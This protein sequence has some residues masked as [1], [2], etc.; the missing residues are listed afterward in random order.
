MSET[1]DLTVIEIKPEQAPAL[2]IANGLDKYL[3]QIREYAK[4]APDVTTQKGRDRIGSLARSVGVSK[5][6]IEEPG[7]AYLKHLKEA[8]KP[9]EEELRR[10][11]R[12][13]DAIRDAILLPRTEYEQ[14]QERLRVE[15]Q[16]IAARVAYDK[17]RDEANDLNEVFD[18]DKA[19]ELANRIDSDHEVALLMNEKFDRD[20]ADAKAEA[21]RL[22]KEHEERIAKEAREKARREAEELAQQDRISAILRETELKEQAA[23]AEA[24]RIAAEKKAEQDR[25][26][27]A[28]KAEAERLAA[29]QKAEREKQE[30]I[31]AEQLKAKQESDRIQREA[32]QKEDARLAEEKRIADEAAAR[33]ANIEHQKTINNQVIAILTK[34]GISQD[35]AKECV[36]AI[37]K[38]QNASAASG[39]KPPVQ[40][41][42]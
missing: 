31:A 9:A 2:Y 6:T 21:E 39:M 20:A 38:N 18:R 5:K 7:R 42:Y 34:A 11:T 27:A 19:A 29:A 40:I 3:E 1:T 14:E 37:V 25:I 4:E 41:N 33:A 22:Q 15:A 35:C 32:K 12:E 26:D 24:N 16:A 10:F 28:N 23:L 13:C 8:V 36:I 17:M 30:A